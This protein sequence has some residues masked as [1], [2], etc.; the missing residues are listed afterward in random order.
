[1]NATLLAV[2]L[3]L[4][5]PLG[6]GA[7]ASPPTHDIHISYGAAVVEGHVLTVRIRFFKDDLEGALGGHTGR[8]GYAMHATP[9][10]DADFL[11]YLRSHFVV[12][13]G[14]GALA[15]TLVGSGE[16]ELDREPVWWYAF[17][18]EAPAPLTS[19]RV[20]NTLLTEIFDDQTNIVKFVFFPSQEQKT[21]SF[22][23]GDESFQVRFGR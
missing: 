5:P 21:Y 4:A 14:S 7:S 10:V 2:L 23:R 1:M 17:Q 16:D 6:A 15:A 11:A 19:F 20:T 13:A 3:A 22:G 18:F 12:D 8:S 9:E